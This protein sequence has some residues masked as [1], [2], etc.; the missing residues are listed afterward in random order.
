MVFLGKDIFKKVISVC[1]RMRC[2]LSL[3]GNFS[4]ALKR[5]RGMEQT[6]ES[7]REGRGGLGGP[8]WGVAGFKSC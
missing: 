1:K 8:G 5:H 2:L 7:P 3:E 4:Q 6:V